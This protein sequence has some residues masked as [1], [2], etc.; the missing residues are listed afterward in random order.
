[1]IHCP[2]C[3]AQTTVSNIASRGDS[4][5]ADALQIVTRTRTCAECARTT[6][7]TELRSAE[8]GELRR[9]AYLWQRHAATEAAPS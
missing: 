1:M 3:G 8:L 9:L 2:A 4:R 7:T 6:H 5:I